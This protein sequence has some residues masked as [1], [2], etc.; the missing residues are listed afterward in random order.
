M[1][2]IISVKEYIAALKENRLLGLKC[3]ECGFVTS[4]PRLTC[5]KCSG[6]NLAV[7]ELSGKGKI[8]T[9]TSVY[10]PPESHRG[11]APYLVILVELNEGPWIMGNLDGVDPST[12]TME[13]ISKNVKLQKRLISGEKNPSADVSPLFILEN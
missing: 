10:I 3:R 5:R 12:A 7:T 1:G 8:T 4:P 9:F 2:P 11:R 6:Q 13:L